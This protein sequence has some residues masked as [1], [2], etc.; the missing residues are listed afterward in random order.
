MMRFTRISH[1]FHLLPSP[2]NEPSSHTTRTTPTAAGWGA[3]VFT[4][5]GTFQSQDS[6]L[7]FLPFGEIL[8]EILGNGKREILGES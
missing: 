8:G 7:G 2:S 6:N 5:L 4:K 3:A 1:S